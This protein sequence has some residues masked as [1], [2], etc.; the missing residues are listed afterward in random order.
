MRGVRIASHHYSPSLSTIINS[1]LQ[2]TNKSFNHKD[3]SLTIMNHATN[4]NHDYQPV[5]TTIN[6]HSLTIMNPQNSPLQ[7]TNS[8]SMFMIINQCQPLSTSINQRKPLLT[9]TSQPTD[10][11]TAQRSHAP[12][13]VDGIAPQQILRHF[14]QLRGE[15]I[16]AR[17]V[18]QGHGR[19]PEAKG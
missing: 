16:D 9:S 4:V 6:N 3:L 17:H 11:S 18:C 10:P 1:P 15:A 19:T 12:S 14:S 7:T 5:G 2:L 8:T 13:F